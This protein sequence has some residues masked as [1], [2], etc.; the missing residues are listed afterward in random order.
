MI[1]GFDDRLIALIEAHPSITIGTCDRALV[2]SMSRGFGA[3]V[4]DGGTA[5][6]VLI[7]EWPGRKALAN[8]EETGRIAATFTV[9]ETFD[10]YQIKGRV[11]ETG[12]CT[13][14]DLELAAAYIDTIRRRIIALGEPEALVRVTFSPR[15]LFRVR[16][17]PE[18]LFLQTPGKRA[19][20]RL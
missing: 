12:D 2:P 18:E 11:A 16:I 13:P 14:A 1:S 3:R 15:G 6:E 9:P 20:E 8:I 17:I 5:V 10:A 19:G 7:S 4:I